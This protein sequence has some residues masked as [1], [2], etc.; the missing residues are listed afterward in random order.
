MLL[1]ANL[2]KRE[3]ERASQKA[4]QRAE[5]EAAIAA[6]A[7]ATEAAKP[8]TAECGL[9]PIQGLNAST[10]TDISVGT[11]DLLEDE[12]ERI[13]PKMVSSGTGT[14]TAE[15]GTRAASIRWFRTTQA[16]HLQ[17]ET[18]QFSDW[19]HGIIKRRLVNCMMTFHCTEDMFSALPAFC[20]GSLP[21]T[22]RIAL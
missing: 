13:K 4:K 21:V 11:E 15:I 3:R 17:D 12:F 7:A 20:E 8:K 18:G 2:Q 1:P 22:G 6:I 10:G 5:E 16:D 19:F 9:D 14:D